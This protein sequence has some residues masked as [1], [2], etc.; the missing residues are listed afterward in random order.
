MAYLQPQTLQLITNLTESFPIIKYFIRLS[1]GLQPSNVEWEAVP[2][3]LVFYINS[4]SWFTLA[5]LRKC[6]EA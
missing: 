6:P 3:L 5:A 1:L 2:V 4:I